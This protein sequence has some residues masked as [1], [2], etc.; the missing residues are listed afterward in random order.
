MGGLKIEH[1]NAAGEVTKTINLQRP[2]RRVSMA[3]LVEQQTGWKY[4]KRP[5]ED[6][7]EQHRDHVISR[8][9]LAA[10]LSAARSLASQRH[11]S[12]SAGETLIDEHYEMKSQELVEKQIIAL[13]DRLDDLSP[14]EQLVETLREVG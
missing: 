3:D 9:I 14:A 1:K 8:V 13:T 10:R 6:L 5:I 4:D 12:E 7:D 11:A 2:W